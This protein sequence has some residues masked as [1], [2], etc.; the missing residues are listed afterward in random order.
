MAKWF[1]R[2]DKKKFNLFILS[3][4]LVLIYA[5][6]R[7]MSI[8]TY[9]GTY[10]Y[11]ENTIS[12]SGYIFVDSNLNFPSVTW[13]GVSLYSISF[14]GLIFLYLLLINKKDIGKEIYVKL[15]K[16][17]TFIQII[18]LLLLPVFPADILLLGHMV[19][20]IA[21]FS[22]IVITS[23]IFMLCFRKK[24]TIFLFICVLT[25][26]L[27]L[28]IVYM[29]YQSVLGLFEKIYSYIAIFTFINSIY[30]LSRIED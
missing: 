28:G 17:L 11:I 5:I 21:L 20:T 14:L 26:F 22:S 7:I 30:M 13:F 24:F 25:F 23:F 1:I 10:T 8:I 19:L 29:Q 9:N 15:L 16:L 12:S 27:I 3:L 6:G 4:I 18:C 2:I